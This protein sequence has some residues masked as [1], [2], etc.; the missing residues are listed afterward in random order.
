MSTHDK[1]IGNDS[2]PNVRA[3]LNALAAAQASQQSGTADPPAMLS[4]E[5]QARTDLGVVRR[6]NAANSGWILD[7]ALAETL[8][9]SRSSNT[10]LALADY[11][12]FFKATG[13]FTQTLTAAATLGDGWHCFYR[14]DGTGVITIDPNGAETIDGATT[15][16][17]NGSQSCMIFCDGSNF[18]TMGLTPRGPKVITFSRDLTLATAAIGYTGFG[19]RPRAVEFKATS[20]AASCASWGSDDGATALVMYDNGSS[21]PDAY[22]VT[23]GASILLQTSAGNYQTA[24]VQSF[25]ADGLTLLWT[26]GGTPTGTASIICTAFF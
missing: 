22:L 12:R 16:T 23:G 26:K 2:F 25:D 1:V 15:I 13:S 9:V 7:G 10:I 5:R 18:K 8:G 11:G 4:Y 21:T 20:G 3:D 17:L 24:L 6:R 19:G 14:N